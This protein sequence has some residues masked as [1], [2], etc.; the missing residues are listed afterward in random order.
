MDRCEKFQ[1]LL[2][3]EIEALKDELA[4]WVELLDRRRE[5]AEITE[6]VRNANKALLQL[7]IMGLGHMLEGCIDL[8][9]DNEESIDELSE[10]VKAHLHERLQHGQYPEALYRLVLEKVDKVGAYLKLEV[11]PGAEMGLRHERHEKPA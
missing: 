2:S 5:R 11:Q 10:H 7:E 4:E 6:Y 3:I 8:P 9:I 1:R